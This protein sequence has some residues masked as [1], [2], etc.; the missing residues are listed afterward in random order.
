MPSFD[1]I[2]NDEQLTALVVWL[3]RQATDAPPWNDVARVVKDSG[4]AP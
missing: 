2:L 4:S 1:G 3:R